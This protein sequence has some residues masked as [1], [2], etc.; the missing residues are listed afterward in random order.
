[1]FRLSWMR[2]TPNRPT[3]RRFQRRYR[4]LLAESVACKNLS[5]RNL[6]VSKFLLNLSE[7]IFLHKRVRSFLGVP[8][9]ESP[10]GDLRFKPPLPKK[11]WNGQS[12]HTSSLLFIFKPVNFVFQELSTPIFCLQHAG[13]ILKFE[14]STR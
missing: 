10:I 8:F 13:K 11:P 14:L 12:L 2:S 1:M 9:A 4:Y 7:S 6:V 5:S 3:S